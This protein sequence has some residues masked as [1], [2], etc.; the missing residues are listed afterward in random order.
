LS[1]LVTE[2]NLPLCPDRRSQIRL[3]PDRSDGGFACFLD[4]SSEALLEKVQGNSCSRRAIA[5]S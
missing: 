3:S 4:K 1:I 5:H 2:K